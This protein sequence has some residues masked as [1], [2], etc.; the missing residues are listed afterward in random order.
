MSKAYKLSVH[1]DRRTILAGIGCHET[2]SKFL[3]H[4]ALLDEVFKAHEQILAPEGYM[5]LNEV[6]GRL[7]CQCLV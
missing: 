4:V 6:D 7:E 2:D 1:F 5:D 3:E